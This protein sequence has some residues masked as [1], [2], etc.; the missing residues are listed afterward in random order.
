M[1]Q[2]TIACSIL[3]LTGFC[4]QAKADDGFIDIHCHVAGIGAGK[5]GCFVSDAIKRSWKYRIFLKAFGITEKDLLQEGDGLIFKR[6]SETLARSRTVSSAVVLAMDGVVTEGGEL[7]LQN[8]ELY[9]PNEFVAAE[10]KKYPNLLYGASINPY[11]RDALERLEKAAEDGAVLVKWLPPIQNIDPSDPRLIPFYR[12]LRDL[13]LPLLTHT[14]EE[15]SFTRSYDNLGD[16]GLLRLPLSLGVTVIAAHS[17]SSGR[18]R[19]ESNYDRFLRLCREY[20]NLYAD[21]SS[22]T[23]INR[24]GRL[25]RVLKQPELRGR[26]L[27]GT[28]M[29]L[30]N[31]AIVSSFAF[32]FRLSPRRMIAISRIENPW[33]RDVALKQAL[34][35]RQEIFLNTATQ[36]GKLCCANLF[37]GR[38][39]V[40]SK[41]SSGSGLKASPAEWIHRA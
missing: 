24:L 38:S 29:P 28:D 15:R 13:G 2:F 22:L 21:I 39:S 33:D 7:D 17:A 26:L 34:G 40:F 18:S 37:V 16:P 3:A 35:V 12:T 20:P 27:Y 9:I 8:T 6:L 11:R 41:C 1:R 36:G 4:S 23:Q 10:V 19:G 5:S 25:K 32:P 30:I 31:T 14:G